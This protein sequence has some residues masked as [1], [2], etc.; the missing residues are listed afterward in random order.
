MGKNKE[1]ISKENYSKENRPKNN[2]PPG[3]GGILVITYFFVLLFLGMSVY[4]G[5]FIQK[6][7]KE[8]INNSYNK[9]SA[10]LE[11]RV[12]R[13]KILGNDGEILAETITENGKSVRNYPYNDL[14]SHVVGRVDKGRTGIEAAENITLVTSNSNIFINA[15][16]Q[17]KGDRITGDDVLTTLD[18]NL[19]R[20]A[21]SALGEQRGAVVV[22][23]PSTGKILAMV[24]KP[25]YDPNSIEKYWDELNGDTDN[26]PLLNRA[27][28]GLYP[29]GSTF[30]I[31][32]SLAFMRQNP[33]YKKY[34]YECSGNGIFSSVSINCY[35]QRV[36]GSEDLVSSFANS[37]NTS[38]ANI[39]TDLELSGFKRVC[40][41]F[42]FNKTLPTDLTAKVSSFVLDENSRSDEVPQTAIGQGKT[43]I[44]PILNCMIAA[45]IANNGT[46]MCPYV[47][48]SVIS[49]DGRVVLT[50]EPREYKKI[51][52]AKE[53][54][55]LKKMMSSVVTDGTG[56]PL[57]NAGYTVAGKT[58]SAEF[59]STKATHSWFVGY[60]PVKNP[61]IAVCVIV[62]N[63][64]NG[65]V[66][67]MPVVRNVLDAYFYR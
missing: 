35:D 40:E 57:N 9:R 23:E 45:T 61:E 56:S 53:V 2:N 42:L 52:K 8:I 41:N 14:F 6:D 31:L 50:H 43:Q 28:Q 55:F 10:M 25:D 38:F 62:E 15:F 49:N 1:S 13:G 46:M 19:Q 12:I 29:P 34:S 22:M 3:N 67:S 60:A 33:D 21:Y 59:D 66:Y 63:T 54:K 36:H 20:A 37:C 65:D 27:T 26:S 47:V 64:G 17:I 16:T 5:Y 39:G 51:L 7:A 11:K 4:Y 44:T 24:S 32:S 48:D 18:V 58:G 30:K